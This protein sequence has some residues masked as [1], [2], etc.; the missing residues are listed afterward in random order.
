MAADGYALPES[1][2]VTMNGTLIG[3][4]NY[5]YDRQTGTITIPEGK[6]TG[7]IVITA[8]GVDV[9]V[10]VVSVTGVKMDRT[11]AS[12]AQN[13]TLKLTCTIT[14]ADALTKKWFGA[15]AI[16]RS[17]PSMRMVPCMAFLRAP[18]PSRS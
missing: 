11:S 7:N 6:I 1:I 18:R 16:L 15:P 5:T 10:E 4:A 12:V 8:V 3:E 14:P 9:R 2:V 13:G 17:L